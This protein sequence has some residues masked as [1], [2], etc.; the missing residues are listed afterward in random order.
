MAAEERVL[1]RGRGE[2]G[3]GAEGERANSSSTRR[4]VRFQSPEKPTL[5]TIS[6]GR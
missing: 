3:E 6:Q 1:E 5:L 4:P 2:E